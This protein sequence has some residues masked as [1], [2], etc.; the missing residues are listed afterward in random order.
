MDCDRKSFV[1]FNAGKAQLVS[2]DWSYN[3][4]AIDV[5]MDWS[6][7]DEKSSFKILVLTFSSKLDWGYYIISIL[8]ITFKKN[9]AL[10][11]SM[12]FLSPEVALISINLPFELAS[13]TILMSGL[14]LLAAT[15]NC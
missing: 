6:V 14:V 5:K 8:K 7:L 10:I 13:N 2:F 4:G 3:T 15:W 1:D 9:G 11:H 12:K